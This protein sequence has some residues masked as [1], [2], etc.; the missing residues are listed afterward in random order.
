MNPGRKWDYSK[1]E[2]GAQQIGFLSELQQCK[3]YE[4][5]YH[6]DIAKLVQAEC[7]GMT[8]WDAHRRR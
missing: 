5:Y 6:D 7:Q 2:V 1:N 3:H 4:K 8:A